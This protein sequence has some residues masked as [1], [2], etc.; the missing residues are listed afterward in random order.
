[1]SENYDSFCECDYDGAIDFY[2]TTIRKARKRHRCS[3]C[4]GAIIPGE[5][6]EYAA[7]KQEEEMWDAKTC[8]RCL[9]LIDWIKAHVPCYCRMHGDLF[10]ERLQYLVEDARQTPGFAFGML[11]RIV[12]VK[13]HRESQ[14]GA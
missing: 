13:R 1:M 10:E 6:Y 11:R 4:N 3:E 8:A 14:S 7:G 9:A 12:A 2:S 5:T